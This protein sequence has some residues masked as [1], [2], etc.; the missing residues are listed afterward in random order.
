MATLSE[1][2]EAFRGLSRA[3]GSFLDFTERHPGEAWEL[4]VAAVTF[5]DWIPPGH[6][7]T[8]QRWPTFLG[9]EKLREVRRTTVEVTRL[10]KSVPEKVFGGDAKEISRFYGIGNEA[11]TA[12]LLTPPNGIEE[13][14]ARCDLI[15][16]AA[17]FKCLEVNASARIGG[18]DVRIWADLYRRA[19]RIAEF[20]AEQGLEISFVDTLEV[21]FSHIVRH[22]TQ[23]GLGREGVLNVSVVVNPELAQANARAEDH[24]NTVYA[25]VLREHGLQGRVWI[26][27]YH[28]LRVTAG[29]PY[30]RSGARI[31]AVVEYTEATTPAEIYR[32]FKAEAVSLYGGPVSAILADKRNLA[33]LSELQGSD[34]FSAEDRDLIRAH[35]PWSR[36]V[37]P[38]GATG[39]GGKAAPTFGELLAGRERLV[40]KKGL[41][42]KGQD[43]V[44]GPRTSP[45]DW[46]TALRRALAEGR[47]MVQEHVASRPYLY[48][49][50]ECG[51]VP[52]EVVWGTFCFG[53]TYGGEFLRM[54]AEGLGK[55]IV[56]FLGGATKGFI[57]TAE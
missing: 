26:G 46:E 21:M 12:L 43:V 35:V 6:S 19:P 55:G 52:H 22:S 15:D 34:L 7:S 23:R 9:G 14:F 3:A 42:F 56:S 25:E 36:L 45:Q 10:V 4:N 57:F 39:R 29:L 24:F 49:D 40:L 1:A 48:Y 8:L 51:P 18:W 11:L 28:D 33:L 2:A 16:S 47:W 30:H 53:S 54:V 27:A 38:D 31:H 17:G 32:C 13:G 41:S 37:L 20:L 5:P 44:I 50:R